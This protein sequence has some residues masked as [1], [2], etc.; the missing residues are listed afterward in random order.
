[1]HFHSKVVN[2]LGQQQDMGSNSEKG[3]KKKLMTREIFYF[4]KLYN[5]VDRF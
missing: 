2:F 3:L 4:K 1:M 5:L